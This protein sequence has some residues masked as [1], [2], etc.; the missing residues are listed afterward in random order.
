MLAINKVQNTLLVKGYTTTRVMAQEQD[1]TKGVLTLTLQPGLIGN[2]TQ[3]RLDTGTLGWSD[4]HNQADY[5]AEHS[6]VALSTGGPVGRELLTNMAGSM[7]SGANNS[8][9]V[10]GTTKAAVSE[11]A[12][13]IRDTGRQQ[14]Q[15]VAGLNRDTDHANDGRISPIFNKEKEQQRLQQAQLIGEIGG[16]AMDSILTQGDIAGLKAQTDPAALAQAREQ[17]EKSGRPG[18]DAAVMQ[19]AYNNAIRHRQRPAKGGAGD[20]RGNDRAGG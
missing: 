9:H 12:L 1:L 19:Q 2:K 17:L 13:T 10:S 7:L 5:R 15:N 16:Q 8:G 4:I 11:G 6:G 3:N 20:N 18:D 14:Q